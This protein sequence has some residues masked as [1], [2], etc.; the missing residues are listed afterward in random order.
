M[1]LFHERQFQ[2]C[3]L[4]FCCKSFHF[5]THVQQPGATRSNA[6]AS[7][8]KVNLIRDIDASLGIQSPLQGYKI[9]IMMQKSLM[10]HFTTSHGNPHHPPPPGQQLPGP[11][12]PL[13]LRPS[14][15]P[16]RPCSRRH[17]LMLSSTSY[18]DLMLCAGW[19]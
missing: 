14:L 17:F 13:F 19:S 8:V 10:R 12:N 15:S 7:F 18:I 4:I 3:E 5:H 16:D 6:K 1:I 2:F 9:S 11:Q